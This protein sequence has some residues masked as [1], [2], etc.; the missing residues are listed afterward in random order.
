MIH[1]IATIEV[2]PGTRSAFLEQFAWVVPLVRAEDGCLE[3][4]AGLDIPTS[5]RVQVPPRENVV[6][7]V[8]K[9]RDLPALEAHLAAPHMSEYRERVKAFV[10][11]VALQVLQ[12]A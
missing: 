3:Y 9:W 10:V 11:Q 12:P 8:E 7:V 4:G 1:V 6:I 2:Q 5:I